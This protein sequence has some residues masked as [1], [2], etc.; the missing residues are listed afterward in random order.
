MYPSGNQENKEEKPPPIDDTEEKLSPEL[1]LL[2]QM[3]AEENLMHGMPLQSNNT[4]SLKRTLTARSRKLSELPTDTRPNRPQRPEDLQ[5]A[6]YLN[7]IDIDIE[8][9][10][11]QGEVKEKKKKTRPSCWVTS[12]WILTC[13]TPPFLL[14]ACGIKDKSMQQIWREKVSLVIIIVFLCALV[15]FLTFGFNATLCGIAPNRI[16]PTG[17]KDDHI[18]ISG[19]AFDLK[20][21]VHPTPV[22]GMPI[23]GDLREL[24]AGGKDL[25][26][27]FQTVNY[28]CKDVLKPI[29][30]DDNQGNVVN[31]FPCVSLDRYNPKLSPLDNPQRD[32]CHVSMKARTALKTLNVVGDVYYDWK[33]IH[34]AGTSLMVFNGNVLDLSRLRYLTPNIPLPIQIA[35]IVGPGSAFIGRDATYWL[36]TTSDRLK[37]GKCLTDILKV[38]V[39]D[40]RS[41][42]CLLSDI[43]LW[44][45]LAVILGVVL[46]RFLLALVFGWFISWNL[47]TIREETDEDRKK[48]QEQVLEWEMNNVEDMHYP[49]NNSIVCLP[50]EPS[51]SELKPPQSEY[52][53]PPSPALKISSVHKHRFFPSKSRFSQPNSPMIANSSRKLGSMGFSEDYNESPHIPYTLSTRF[54]KNFEPGLPAV[55]SVANMQAIKE[56]NF[57]FNLIHTLMVVTCYSEGE[58]GLRTTLDSLANADYPSSHKMLLVIC[59][60]IITG[61]GNGKSTPDIVLSMMKDELVPKEKAQPY[62]YVAISDGVKRHN[63]AKVYA[64]YYKYTDSDDAR[65]PFTP[66]EKQQR[67]PMVVIVKCGTEAEA[68]EKKP[69]NRGKRDSQVILMNTMQKIFYGDRMCELEYQLSKAIIKVTG[70]HPGRFETCLMVDADTKIYPDSLARMIACMSRD[71]YIM[72]LCGETKIAN[73]GDSWVT[74]IQVFEYY[75]SHHMSKAFESI[76]GGVTCLPGCFCMYRIVARKGDRIVPIFCSSNI[77]EMYCENVVDTLHKKNLLLLGEDRYLTTL[78]LRTFPKRKMVF[79]PQ[80]ICK[81]VVPD[82]FPVLL[83]QRRRWINSTVHNLL[84]LLLIRDLCGT[85]CFSMQFIV[86]MELIGTAVLPAAILFTLYLIVISFFVTPV[87]I[88]P[89]V[90]LAAILGLPAVLISLT[91]RKMVYIG[92]MCVYLLSLPIWNFILPAYAYWHFDD[93]SWGQTRLVD[94]GEKKEDH[95]KCEGEFDSSGIVMKRFDEWHRHEMNIIREKQLHARIHPNVFYGH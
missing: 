85:F 31:Y 80:A 20:T 38:G 68:K 15:G 58:E 51:S 34:E 86:F 45:S 44:L 35:Q 27:M 43:T 5:R 52:S 61:S 64:G 83:S 66:E 63:K 91:T 48:R 95:G 88:I 1:N 7:T 93:F 69:G 90:L 55:E 74:A 77:V 60:G 23:S 71:P 6:R 30:S 82:T 49:R 73:K 39:V 84:E 72:G 9:N 18:V 42:G 70:H 12:T 29:L 50:E 56:Y 32:G 54:Y 19:R 76:F 92:W 8:K 78:M 40:T 79:V 16:L 57:N 28:N 65:F 33:D 17:V 22:V 21:F 89:L 11:E 87:P 53:V 13:W 37:L 46:I 3:N 10:K 62:S 75:I 47:G 94:G 4:Q 14:K 26:F 25:S 59:D 24:D 36:S 81:T 2:D 67:V 41:T